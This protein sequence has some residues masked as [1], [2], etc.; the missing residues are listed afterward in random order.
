MA[1]NTLAQINAMTHDEFIATLGGIFEHS[2]WVAEG[3]VGAR[4]F[5]SSAELHRAMAAVVAAAPET[6]KLALLGAHPELAG[7]D[8]RKKLISEDSIGEQERAGL[9]ALSERQQGEF[10]RMNGQY[11]ER[12]GFP[13]IVAVR[14]Y[15]MTGI[16]E[17]FRARLGNS[18]EEELATAL[19]EICEIARIRLE[20][21][22]G[23]QIARAEQ[24]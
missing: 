2:P 23:E 10:D 5:G 21:L 1:G 4:P 18:R 15:T 19:S 11:R 12:F 9:D 13:F 17:A 8:A 20:E 24:P 3:A 22:T 6:D 16:L 14:N 7:A